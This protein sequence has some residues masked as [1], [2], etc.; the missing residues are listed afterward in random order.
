MSRLGRPPQINVDSLC[1]V[2]AMHEL[3]VTEIA[4]IFGLNHSTV[5]YHL[6]RAGIWKGKTRR[7]AARTLGAKLVECST[8]S[9]GAAPARVVR[10]ALQA[11]R[12][13]ERTEGRP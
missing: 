10:L 4:E 3:T 13:I 5:H 12:I 11:R 7:R 2:Y 1:R 8:Q 6:K 9:R